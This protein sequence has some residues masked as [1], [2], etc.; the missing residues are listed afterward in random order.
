M[1]TFEIGQRVALRSVGLA[2]ITDFAGGTAARDAHPLA[3]GEQAT[4]YV[5]STPSRVSVI[6]IATAHELLRPLIAADEARDLLQRLRVDNVEPGAELDSMVTKRSRHVVDNG[7]PADHADFLRELYALPEVD[8]RQAMAI[9]AYEDFVLAEI[10]EVLGEDY[11]TLEAEM[12]S[13]YPAFERR[14]TGA[15]PD[16]PVVVATP[17][18]PVTPGLKTR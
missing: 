14:R 7:T 17:V 2:T 4:F 9:V 15:K 3:P 12:R 11:A 1:T 6:P 16:G 10:A 5:A 8:H 18:H 13:R